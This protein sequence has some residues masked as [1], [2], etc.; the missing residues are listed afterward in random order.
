[1]DNSVKP[2]KWEKV[3][4]FI[5]STFNDLE[6]RPAELP[7]QPLA[8]PYMS[9]STHTAP[10]IQP[11]I[12]NQH[13]NAQTIWGYVCIFPAESIVPSDYAGSISYISAAPTV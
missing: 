13:P 5:S 1:M 10:I 4:I 3:H 12:P 9:L 7:R 2:V 11:Q 8:E 6:S